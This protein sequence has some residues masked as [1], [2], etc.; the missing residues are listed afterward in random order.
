MNMQVTNCLFDDNY[1]I[2]AILD[3]TGCQTLPFESFAFPPMKVVPYDDRF[4]DHQFGQAL[5]EERRIQWIGYRALFF[6]Y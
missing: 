2:T 3:W 6:E 4:L 1:N 5:R